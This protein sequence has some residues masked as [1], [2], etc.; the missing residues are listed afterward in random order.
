[1]NSSYSV[2]V[3]SIC[4][5]SHGDVWKLTSELLPRFVTA[6]EFLVYVPESE[7]GYFKTITNP[8]IEIRAQEELGKYFYAPLE[9]AVKRADNS[10]RFGWYLQ[11]FYKIQ[12]IQE[13]RNQIVA[14][15]DAD[16]VPVKKIE[17]LD[18]N[19]RISYVNSSKELHPPY[20]KNIKL[21]LGL[22]RVQEICFVIPGFPMKREWIKDFICEIESKHGSSWF[23]AIINCTDFREISGFSETE[24]LG[25]WV[26]NKYPNQ[27]TYRQGS[28]ERFGQSR[29]G[30]ARN[31]TAEKLVNIG[32]ENN[33]EIITFENWDFRGLKKYLKRFKKLKSRL[34]E[35]FR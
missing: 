3:I 8:R 7:I 2:T 18:E 6:S 11:Q 34:N 4:S 28:W 5:K 10:Q 25:T 15:W 31:F 27:W 23:E 17:L 35:Y 16:C 24:S 9:N 20:F 32:T 19:N 26:A 13:S 30:Y 1:M 21:L 12:A 29:F 33:L 14:I 22:E